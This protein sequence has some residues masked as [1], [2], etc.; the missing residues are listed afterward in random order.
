METLLSTTVGLPIIDEHSSHVV[1]RVSDVLID[2]ET[3]K[4]VAFLIGTRRMVV[5]MDVTAWERD[6]LAISNEMHILDHG[7]VIRVNEVLKKQIPVAGN[8]VFTESGIYIGRVTDIVFD[9]RLF[10][11]KKIFVSKTFL[12]FHYDH[13]LV[14]T[15][16]IVEI[17]Q[18]AVI[19]SD[20]FAKSRS[21][22]EAPSLSAA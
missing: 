21:K 11:M 6:H 14:T 17:R 8:K 9:P 7:D 20:V 18:D 10:E 2:T 12:I 1:S 15:K 4:V 3:G 19:V 22:A 13:R 16:Q 5:P